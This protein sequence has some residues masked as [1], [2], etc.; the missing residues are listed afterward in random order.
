VHQWIRANPGILI[1][2]GAT[3]SSPNNRFYRYQQPTAHDA[4]IDTTKTKRRQRDDLRNPREYAQSHW[5]SH[6]RDYLVRLSGGNE[7]EQNSREPV[8]TKKLEG[9]ANVKNGVQTENSQRTSSERPLAG[10]K[11]RV[12][13]TSKGRQQCSVKDIIRRAGSN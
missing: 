10:T 7:S 3:R 6:P 5:R 13:P 11:I 9:H 12:K 4:M 2:R 8:Q 1:R